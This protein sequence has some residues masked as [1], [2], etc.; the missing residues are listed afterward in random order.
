MSQQETR[1]GKIRLIE[2]LENETLEEQCKR[3]LDVRDELESYYDSWE[4]AVRDCGDDYII[5]KN[6][7]YKILEDRS[8]CGDD[9]FEAKENSDGTISYMLS[10][11]NSGC[12]YSEAL[13]ESLKNMEG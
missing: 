12:G 9:I 4:E 5:H 10:Y 2:K 7:I 1:M 8:C 6:N 3:I 13:K 11:H